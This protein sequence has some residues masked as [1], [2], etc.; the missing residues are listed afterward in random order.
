MVSFKVYCESYNR[1]FVMAPS[2][3][4]GLS[5]T[6]NELDSVK[7]YPYGFWV[8]KWG[9]WIYTNHH[10]ATARNI[11]E[12]FGNHIGQ[13]PDELSNDR[14]YQFLFDNGYIRIANSY[15]GDDQNVYFWEN[16]SEG[17]EPSQSQ[18]K[19]LNELTRRWPLRLK[20]DIDRRSY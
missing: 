18:Q 16:R 17:F 14:P 9:H 12:K 1:D 5:N 6:L 2:K 7:P 3:V 11:I 15:D 13:D 4:L 10:E 19:F 8:N 20:R